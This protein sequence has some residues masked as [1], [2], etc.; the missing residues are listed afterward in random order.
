MKISELA[1]RTQVPKQTIHYYIRAGLLPRPRKQGSNSADYD[2]SYVERIRLIKE[3]QNDFFFPLPTIKKILWEHRGATKQAMLKLRIEFFRPIEQYLGTGVQGDAAFLEATG[4]AAR[5]LPRLKEWGFISQKQK[6]GVNVY[7]KDDITIAKVMVK[8]AQLGINRRNNFD[9]EVMGDLARDF[10]D[11]VRHQITNW[12]RATAN[13]DPAELQNLWIAA[14]EIMGVL[15][16]HLYQKYA[17]EELG[18][19]LPVRLNSGK[20]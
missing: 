10:R 6:D 16:Y 11:I 19:F 3:L 9:A 14:H 15:F 13:M 2:E 12:L 5:W 1:K 7:T 8:M 17:I 4:L 18:E 20:P